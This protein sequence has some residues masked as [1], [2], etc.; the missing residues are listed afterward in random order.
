MDYPISPAAPT[1]MPTERV[2]IIGSGN[3][4]SAIA[5]IVA[6]NA[7][8]FDRFDKIVNMWVFEET[9]TY[10]GE[11]RKLTDVINTY[12]E[13][14]KY[15]PGFHFPENV[16]AIPD[17]AAAVSD[18]TLLVFVL[19]HQFLPNILPQVR[20]ALGETAISSG[21]VRAIS[22]IKGIDFNESGLVLVS[23]MIRKGL[24]VTCDVL[25][26]ANVANEVRHL[27]GAILLARIGAKW[28]CSH[29]ISANCTAP[30]PF[31]HGVCGS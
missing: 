13:N 27:Y 12:K 23:D 18:A 21:R 15:L 17:L 5:R 24:G 1:P 8:H 10:K 20:T 7:H 25:M 26:G 3:W 6:E 4:G 29:C 19:P 30:G 28:I 16:R 9:V 2:A 31:H 11:Q 22:L 14:V